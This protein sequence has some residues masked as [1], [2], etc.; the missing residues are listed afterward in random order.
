MG[1]QRREPAY[2]SRSFLA[3][4]REQ[5]MHAEREQGARREH[6]SVEIHRDLVRIENSQEHDRRQPA[7]QRRDNQLQSDGTA[8]AGTDMAVGQVATTTRTGSHSGND[9]QSITQA[10]KEYGPRRDRTFDN[11]V[12]SQVLYH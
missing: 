5:L 10:G 7:G 12:K 11:L 6:E 3:P 1:T 8:A 4:P 2:V 9:C